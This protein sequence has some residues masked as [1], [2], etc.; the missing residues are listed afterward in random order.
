MESMQG[1]LIIWCFICKASLLFGAVYSLAVNIPAAGAV[2]Y[3]A[4]TNARTHEKHSTHCFANR[5]KPSV[6]TLIIKFQAMPF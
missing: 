4:S 5:D 3:S 1:V 6:S 2:T